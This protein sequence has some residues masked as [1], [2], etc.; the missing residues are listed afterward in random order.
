MGDS[1]GMLPPG[2]STLVAPPRRQPV[3]GRGQVATFGSARTQTPWHPA[4]VAVAP[5]RRRQ[6]QAAT[7]CA[8]SIPVQMICLCHL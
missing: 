7:A 8:E 2:N 1:G 5:D 3:V 6:G 4:I